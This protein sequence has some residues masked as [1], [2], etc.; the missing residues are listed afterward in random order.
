MEK[1]LS[2]R[3]PGD[4]L[5]AELTDELRR[6]VTNVIARGNLNIIRHRNRILN[7]VTSDVGSH[8]P[9]VPVANA[10]QT[11]R[12][13]LTNLIADIVAKKGNNYR[14][15]YY[16]AASY[17][18]AYQPTYALQPG[19]VLADKFKAH[20]WWLPTLGELG[21]VYW[22]QVKGGIFAAAAS[23]SRYSNLTAD[24]HWTSTEYNASYAWYLHGGNGQVLYNNFKYNS[25]AC[26][27]V[28]AF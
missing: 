24:W 27:A 5:P 2:A 8:V 25:R 9:T 21:M 13:V 23:N 28:V 26:R 14:Q 22:Q 17:C 11:E 12:E 6:S 18:Y 10:N 20:N 16:P 19:E 15:F 4:D 3:R 7:G 1:E